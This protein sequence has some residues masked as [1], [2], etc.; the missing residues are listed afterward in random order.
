MSSVI[1][2]RPEIDGLRALAVIPVVLFHSGVEFFSGGFT[3]VN[4]FFVISGYLIT[5][6]IS[7]EIKRK[8]FK[9][10]TFYQKRADRLFPVLAAVLLCTLV[11]GFFFSPPQEF[12]GISASVVS[13]A[14]FTSNIYFW[15]TS[16]YF[17]A[18]AFSIP[19]LHTWSLGIEEQFYIF[20]PVFLI[21]AYR[22]KL[23]VLFVAIAASASFLLATFTLKSHTSA[24]FY[25]LP[26]RAWELLL[27]SVLALLRLPPPTRRASSEWLSWT[28]LAMCLWGIFS[29]DKETLFPGPSA[30]L[31]TT[32][33][34]LLIYST[35]NTQ[36][37]I[38]KLF[39]LQ[40]VATIGKASY[41]IYMWHWPFIVFYGL[42]WGYPTDTSQSI[43]IAT[44]S[45]ALGLTSWATIERWSRGKIAKM[46][47]PK[48]CAYIF[49]F[50]L[51]ILSLSI[52]S[53]LTKGI[54]SRVAPSVVSSELAIND[55]SPYRET[56]HAGERNNL[57]YNEACI[58]GDLSTPP[59]I[60]VWGDSHGVELSAALGEALAT[61]NLSLRQLTYSACPPALNVDQP[62]RPGCRRHNEEVLRA[63]TTDSSIQTVLL[64]AN[65]SNNKKFSQEF[66]NGYK[67]SIDAL[68]SSGKQVISMQPLPKTID[69][70]P[71]M[72]ARSLMLQRDE[73]V[74][75]SIE[76]FLNE[77]SQSFELISELPDSVVK[78]ETWR[79]FCRNSDCFIGD[80]GGAYFFDGHHPSMHGARLIAEDVITAITESSV[81]NITSSNSPQTV[82]LE[83]HE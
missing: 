55:Y 60:A 7:D 34:A 18:S 63:L 35:A 73:L 54:P 30:L 25:L 82:M 56:C 11:I 65:F 48:A 51:P 67:L 52:A 79:R 33:A 80:H 22:L 77:Y 71:T 31:P 23:P 5:S 50:F 78:L 20:F 53:L 58:L 59:S 74:S 21:I 43:L 38:H 45:T 62:T 46:S 10:S 12:K 49:A 13:A 64:A 2:Y 26:T 70:A 83:S 57:D 39:T 15:Q 8:K 6:I 37:S 76:N 47:P 16:N 4:I 1:K 75:T 19:L 72:I 41:S 44:A 17:S 81:N 61:K 28:G 36:N 42:L 69:N 66:A 32:G 3:G 29:F 40:P 24:T 14:T 9:I 27:G 68:L